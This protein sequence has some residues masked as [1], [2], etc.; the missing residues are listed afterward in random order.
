MNVKSALVVFVS[1]IHLLCAVRSADSNPVDGTVTAGNATISSVPNT[2]TVNQTTHKVV[3]DWRDFSIAPGERTLF[4]Q[5]SA[6]ATALNR[7]IGG[8][9]S[10][11]RGSLEANGRVFLIN[12]Q[13]I[14]VGPGGR[15]DTMGFLGSTLD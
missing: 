13:G 8:N 3:I 7:V 4:L 11:I 1:A 12:P 2:L 14:M 9:L 10:Q 6:S 15:I 5:P